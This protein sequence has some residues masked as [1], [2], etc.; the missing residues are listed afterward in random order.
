MTTLL[1]GLF[2]AL[3]V[4]LAGG[5]GAGAR[6]TLD[7]T[8]GVLAERSGRHGWVLAA[9]NIVGSALIGLLVGAAAGPAA[10]ALPANAALV[11]S[12]GFLGG[13]TTFSAASLDVVET[14]Q[15][16][17][18]DAAAARALLVPIGA[19]LACAAGLWV[20]RGL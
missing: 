7:V 5:L 20:G 16:S 19:I 1:P 6:Y 17:G 18:R 8:L 11:L 12:T 3:A 10:P 9:I 14:D 2:L 4:A 13:F 15:R